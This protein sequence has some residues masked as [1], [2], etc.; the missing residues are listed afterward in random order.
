MEVVEKLVK[1]SM[2]NGVLK[3]EMTTMKEENS[4]AINN[5]R[6]RIQ[7]LEKDNATLKVIL[8]GQNRGESV[9]KKRKLDETTTTSSDTS[10]PRGT[11]SSQVAAI[12]HACH[13]KEP[14]CSVKY[15]ALTKNNVQH[16]LI[17]QKR[18][19]GE[20]FFCGQF[21]ALCWYHSE[22]CSGEC[23]VPFCFKFRKSLKSTIAE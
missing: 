20:C 16:A 5:Q 18:A 12:V 10:A 13:C 22:G 3:S 19:R 17:C 14:N 11:F 8:E 23:P 21:Q 1:V 6:L 9:A 4:A 2:E 15:C 7:D